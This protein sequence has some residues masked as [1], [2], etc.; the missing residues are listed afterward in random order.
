M[1]NLI[2]LLRSLVANNGSDLHIIVGAPPIFRIDGK[3]NRLK[4]A[5]LT[6]ENTKNLCYSVLTDEQRCRFEQKLE[7]DFSFAVKD[8]SRFR[9]NIFKQ[10]GAIS[11]AF[12]RIPFTI[13][14]FSQL[15]IPHIVN[16]LLQKPYGLV[17]VTGPTGS[18]KSTTL[19][20]MIDK[21]NAEKAVNIITIEDPIEYVHQH[22]KG[23]IQQREV[24]MDT[25][26]FQDALEH[27]LRQDP[28]IILIGEMREL[29]TVRE[30]LNI[31]ETGHLTFATL[32]TSSCIDSINRIIDIFPPNQQSQARA[33]LSSVLKGVCSQQLLP[34]INGGRVL[35]MEIML[36]NDAIRNLIRDDKVHQIYSQMQ[37][38]QTKSQ[39]VTMNQ[40]LS[41]LCQKGLV[42]VE[43]ASS[44]SPHLE[45]F[46]QM[47]GK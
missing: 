19:A 7:L 3:I 12:R 13:P 46:K 10:R 32:H 4:G 38:G 27:I 23:V 47:V 25:R 26:S 16:S 44:R 40:A 14:D 11:G 17:L 35:A 43:N 28:N 24:G 37:T 45:E 18:G 5:D 29:V 1:P 22:K 8:L 33:Q 31:A 20:T 30:A 42:S 36:P 34:K 39:M 2:A 9:G 6:P 41:E 15:R 21:I